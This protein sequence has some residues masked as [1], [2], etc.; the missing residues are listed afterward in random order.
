MPTRTDKSK[1]QSRTGHAPVGSHG[2]RDETDYAQRH[3]VN[4]A[5]TAFLLA[6]AICIAWTIR[7][8]DQ[9]QTLER[10]IASGRKDCVQISQPPARNYRQLI[11]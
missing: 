6:L 11:H 5:A 10:C 4:L 1:T 2:A 9:Q 3:F 7:I 8:F